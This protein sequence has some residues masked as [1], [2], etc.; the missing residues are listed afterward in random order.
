M[1]YRALLCLFVGNRHRL[2]EVKRCRD[3]SRGSFDVIVLLL[4]CILVDRLS[5]AIIDV[6]SGISRKGLL[7]VERIH[8]R[9][10]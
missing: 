4:L 3:W 6:E 9:Q 1:R 7:F 5:I 10:G 2:W 8:S